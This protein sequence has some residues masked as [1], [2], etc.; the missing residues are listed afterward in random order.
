M[1]EFSER[2]SPT[3]DQRADLFQW[4]DELHTACHLLCRSSAGDVRSVSVG[5][6]L[7]RSPEAKALAR[8]RVRRIAEEYGVAW[9]AQVAAD[10]LTA[11]FSR[12]DQL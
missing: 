11:R 12:L 2:G 5:L 8:E 3:L 4:V 1:D 10:V 9:R 7:P 6:L